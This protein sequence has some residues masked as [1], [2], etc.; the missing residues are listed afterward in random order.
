MQI[1]AIGPIEHVK[2]VSHGSYTCMDCYIGLACVTE[3]EY[4]IDNI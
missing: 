4:N 3:K 1:I 2:R